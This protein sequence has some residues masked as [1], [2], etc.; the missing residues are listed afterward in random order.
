M[1]S[2]ELQ[3]HD[4]PQH[5]SGVE[6]SPSSEAGKRAPSCSLEMRAVGPCAEPPSR[7]PA[8]LMRASAAARRLARSC[9]EMRRF[10][11]RDRSDPGPARYAAVTTPGNAEKGLRG[12]GLGSTAGCT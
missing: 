10:S 11:E 4:T 9:R 6:A 12:T 5:G 8:L 1:I 7:L 2:R 3:A